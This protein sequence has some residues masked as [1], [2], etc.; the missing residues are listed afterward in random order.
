MSIIAAMTTLHSPKNPFTMTPIERRLT[1]HLSAVYALRMLGM[2]IILPV[3]ALYAETLAG[4]D[5]RFWVGFALGA[6]GLTQAILQIP[7]GWASDRWGRKP[8]IFLGLIVF[9]LGSFIAAA[10]SSLLWV[11]VG[12]MLQ[13][14][15][16]ISGVLIALIADGT[17]Y[18]VRTKA[19]AAIGMTIGGTFAVSLMIAPV[20]TALF[21]VPGIFVMTGILA[22]LA[23]IDIKFFVP[24]TNIGNAD[25]NDQLP[26]W[27]AFFS[28]LNNATLARLNFGIFA[29]HAVLMAIFVQIPFN[30][31]QIGLPANHHWM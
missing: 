19:M 8:V 29:L 30:L 2:F 15:G 13:G 1:V 31:R 12:R 22:I 6:Y 7:F 10:S 23:F 24:D 21:G 14:A 3:F 16:A 28:V 18:S 20:L 25:P 26:F 9:A 17:R 5:D 11:I 4:G 27:R